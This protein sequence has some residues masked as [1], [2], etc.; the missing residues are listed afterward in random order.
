MAADAPIGRLFAEA[1][2]DAVEQSL[3]AEHPDFS[4]AMALEILRDRPDISRILVA[5]VD[6]PARHWR[7][8]LA[9]L[10][11]RAGAIAAAAVAL[12]A[13]KESGPHTLAAVAAITVTGVGAAVLTT[14]LRMASVMAESET[15]DQLENASAPTTPAAQ[16]PLQRAVTQSDQDLA[17]PAGDTESAK[18]SA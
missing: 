15:T 16:I 11:H 2:I 1:I 9:R 14:I 3:D 12:K 13:L 17:L 10:A 6:V 5:V 4:R 7:H 8:E 18:T